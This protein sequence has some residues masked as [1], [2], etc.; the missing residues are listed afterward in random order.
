MH[1]NPE[2]QAI[3]ERLLELHT[4]TVEVVGSK[5][6]PCGHRRWVG[7][8]LSVQPDSSGRPSLADAIADGLL[9]ADCEHD[10]IVLLDLD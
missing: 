1:V 10:V 8:M 3:L 7:K 9:G 5:D 4:E 6:A 2:G